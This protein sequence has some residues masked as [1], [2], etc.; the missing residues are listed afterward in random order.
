[1]KPGLIDIENE[2]VNQ[3]LIAETCFMICEIIPVAAGRGSDFLPFY[4][5]L[6]FV[7][8]V[9]CLHSLLVSKD[10]SEV[11]IANYLT[12]RETD[13]V[14]KESDDARKK[15][16]ALTSRIETIF[17]V[18]LRNKVV[19][20]IDSG[21]RH[22][23]FT[24]AYMCGSETLDGYLAVTK[25]TKELFFDLTNYDKWSSVH[26]KI[27]LQSEKIISTILSDD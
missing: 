17:P 9:I 12:Q 23:D 19:A 5:N 11:T 1:M 16:I 20:H 21:F 14:R 25:E 26:K 4:Y 24:C 3:I 10:R 2:I 18:S 6:N 13:S 7:K 22:S 8:G 15:C 27:L